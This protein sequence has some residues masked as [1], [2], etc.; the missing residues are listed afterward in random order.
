MSILSR[1]TADWNTCAV[2]DPTNPAILNLD[3][4]ELDRRVC[5]D[6]VL[7]IT[8]CIGAPVHMSSPYF[9]QSP[10]W[11][12]TDLMNYST[13]TKELHE[14]YIDVEPISGAAIEVKKRI[15]VRACFCSARKNYCEY[16][17]KK[18]KTGILASKTKKCT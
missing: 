17:E 14:T 16:E 2:E 12:G 15:Q 7:D 8:N 3:A 4:C 13:P 5:P 6:G 9:Y 10:E 1:E 11:L 18:S